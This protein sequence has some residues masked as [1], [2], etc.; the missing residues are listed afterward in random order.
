[1]NNKSLL[2][3]DQHITIKPKKVS[4]FRK[5]LLV[6]SYVLIYPFKYGLFGVSK[7]YYLSKLVPCLIFA[8]L[9]CFFSVKL[10]LVMAVNSFLYPYAKTLFPDKGRFKRY[11]DEGIVVTMTRDEYNRSEFNNFAIPYFFSVIFA[12]IGLLTLMFNNRTN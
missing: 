8:G 6:L 4:A 2:V 7:K 12:P 9:A 11:A 10:G 1:M 3:I 5:S